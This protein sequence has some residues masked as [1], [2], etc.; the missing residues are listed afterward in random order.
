MSSE[1]S[2][3]SLIFPRQTPKRMAPALFGIER[4]F[5][6]SAMASLRSEVERG[7]STM[8]LRARSRFHG[9]DTSMVA[10]GWKDWGT[11]GKTYFAEACFL[12]LAAK[13]AAP[14]PPLP[15]EGLPTPN[16]SELGP[17]HRSI[18]ACMAL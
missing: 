10:A 6:Y 1:K 17:P 5:L 15:N 16:R 8:D 2:I 18:A 13:N 12:F 9:V 4:N 11:I 3:P 7:S 14:L